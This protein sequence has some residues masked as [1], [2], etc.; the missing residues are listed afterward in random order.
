MLG[1]SIQLRCKQQM[2][3]C[4]SKIWIED[5]PEAPGIVPDFV[6]RTAIP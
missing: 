6:A 5:R 1:I 2:T 4:M 3:G